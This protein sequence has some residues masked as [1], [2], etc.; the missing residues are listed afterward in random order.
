MRN[1]HYPNL[2]FNFTVN[3]LDGAFFGLGIGFASFGTILPL[4]MSQF[5]TSATLI[6][7]IPA[8]HVAGIQFPSMLM[9]G[10]MSRQK[11]FKPWVL[12]FSFNERSPFLFLALVA[13]FMSDLSPAAGAA[14]IVLLLIVQ[15][16]SGGLGLVAWQSM[17]IKVLPPNLRGTF[18]GVQA[19][20][21]NILA[22]IS[23]VI[24][25]VW[26]DRYGTRTGFAMCF[27]AAFVSLMLSYLMVALTRE[28]DEFPPEEE[29]P[30]P[31]GIVQISMREI[32]RRD[33]NFRWF[34]AVRMLAQFAMMGSAF[35]MVY[36]V[37][38]YGVSKTIAGVLTSAGMIAGIVANPVMGWVG[39]RW[40]HYRVLG[41][42]FLAALF[43]ALTAWL[44]PGAGWFYLVIVLASVANVA[45]WTIAIAMTLQF[46]RPAERQAYIGL[47]NTLI[48][49][50]TILAPVIGGWLADRSGYP[51][52]FLVSVLFGVIT[53][54]FFF[55]KLRDPRPVAP[56][57]PVAQPALPVTTE[58]RPE[59]EPLQPAAGETVDSRP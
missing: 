53:A 39:D 12:L 1:P 55:I 21:F 52:T 47:S 45:V 51:L 7:L 17:L 9:V 33:V 20:G 25:G 37:M 27:F 3:V 36:V 2:R 5:T 50:A 16:L 57:A 59:E 24:A 40:G 32:L 42:G 43:S 31:Q 13:W 38:D 11:R 19:A 22:A 41:A 15:G 8:I 4:F 44:A 35:Y 29:T 34:L 54:A 28:P 10:L 6:G 58:S 56:K 26:L 23:A 18:F 48:A 14:L 30:P 46:G 49:P